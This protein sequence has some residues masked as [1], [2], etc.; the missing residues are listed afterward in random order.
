MILPVGLHFETPNF[1][2]GRR[3]ICFERV[4]PRWE[5]NGLLILDGVTQFSHD[6]AEA[7]EIARQHE[8]DFR[9][10]IASEEMVAVWHEDFP[11]I[12]GFYR[13]AEVEL[14]TASPYAFH[15]L[16]LQL[17][18]IGSSNDIRF[19]SVLLGTVR[20]NNYSVTESGA[21]PMHAPPLGHVAYSPPHT[22]LITRN[23][24]Y[25]GDMTVYRD[26]DFD[27][28]R[29]WSCSARNYYRGAATVNRR[30]A[31]LPQYGPVVGTSLHEAFVESIEI[32]NGLVR[33][34]AT[35]SVG[36]IFEAW[37]GTAWRSQPLGLGV[38]AL[39]PTFS[40]VGIVLNTPERCILKYEYA[41]IGSGITTVKATVIRGERGV[42][43]VVSRDASGSLAA[44]TGV[45]STLTTN[46]L[47]RTTA[48]SNG[49]KVM[50]ATMKTATFDAPTG[51]LAVNSTTLD[52][53]ASVELSGAAAGN[54]AAT[55]AAQ[56]AASLRE[57][58]RALPR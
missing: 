18:R 21:E 29:R 50:L 33:F 4:R 27:Q 51:T 6:H 1:G 28:D 20:T 41:E 37:D 54:T 10:M 55:L 7:C 39:V 43:F 57:E 45:A 24:A 49:H 48:D 19:E 42:R 31:I 14:P 58:V 40:R 15:L 38:Q 30:D 23:V 25:E 3:E 12:D 44:S 9:A 46:R 56:Y 35:E 2:C 22:T 26:V 32:T 8:R 52:F 13:V 5:P 53:F 47:V 36:V 11:E 16:R 17:T 34:S